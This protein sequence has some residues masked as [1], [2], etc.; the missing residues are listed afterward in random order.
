MRPIKRQM[1]NHRK[2]SS[3]S[4]VVE[5]R[6]EF[7]KDSSPSLFPSHTVELLKS[8]LTYFQMIFNGAELDT[9]KV[10]FMYFYSFFLCL[11]EPWIFL[12]TTTMTLDLPFLTNSIMTRSRLRVSSL[13]PQEHRPMWKSFYLFQ[14]MHS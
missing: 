7:Y 11:K 5:S 12:E 4:T 14:N 1:S 3:S 8:R 13:S 2:V 10:I 6:S 9:G